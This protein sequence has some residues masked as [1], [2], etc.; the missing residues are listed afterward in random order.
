MGSALDYYNSFI[1]TY[2]PSTSTASG[3]SVVSEV[4]VTDYDPCAVPSLVIEPNPPNTE[5][6]CWVSEET[7][8]WIDEQEIL[9]DL[10]G[11]IGFIGWTCETPPPDP[12]TPTNVLLVPSMSNGIELIGCNDVSG[13]LYADGTDRNDSYFVEREGNSWEIAVVLPT[14][15]SKTASGTIGSKIYFFGGCLDDA[16]IGTDKLRGQETTIS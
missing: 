9:R 3:S 5:V 12:P 15:T 11:G 13:D 6:S 16:W 14:M 10:R 4:G 7:Q 8:A 2:Y 1:P